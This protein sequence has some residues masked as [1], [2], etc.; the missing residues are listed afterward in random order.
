MFRYLLIVLFFPTPLF[1]DLVL[2]L[3]IA[4][5]APTSSI[6]TV[7]VSARSS[8]D[9]VIP[10]SGAN[11]PIDLGNDG[12][13]VP[14]GFTLDSVFSTKFNVTMNTAIPKS[15]SEANQAPN[16]DAT[17]NFDGS[18]V[19]ITGESEPI[20]GIRVAIAEDVAPGTT[21]PLSFV[22]EPNP[23]TFFL[24]DA[25]DGFG[26]NV[27]VDVQRVG[28]VSVV[29]EASSFWCLCAV[30]A[31]AFGARWSRAVKCRFLIKD[32]PKTLPYST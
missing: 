27:S 1:A 25:T 6:A 16:F 26:A 18:P 17:V 19:N 31:W 8:D 13:G 22:S 4:P 7:L 24:V 32:R 20:F 14:T 12:Y 9:T 21:I 10:L 29:P 30:S 28:S 15:L 11:L 2:E 5:P 23:K 3:A